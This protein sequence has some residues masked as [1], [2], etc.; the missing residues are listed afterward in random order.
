MLSDARTLPDGTVLEA[1]LLI[2][3]AGV[4]GI[5]IAREFSE[6]SGTTTGKVILLEAGGDEYDPATQA[7]YEG[8]VIGNPSADTDITRLRYFGG[9]SNHWH[10]FCRPLDPIDFEQRS[11]V[12]HSGWPFDLSSLQPYYDRAEPI[13]ELPGTA[14]DPASWAES[15]APIFR[16]SMMKGRLRPA[17]FQKS[18]PTLMGLAY[19]DGLKASS[20]IDIYFWANAMELVANDSGQLIEQV[21]CACLEGPRF[22]VR[23]KQVVLATGGIENARLLLAS[24]R[25]QPAG[26][27]NGYDRVGRYFMDHPAHYAGQIVLSSPS[28]LARAPASK[29]INTQCTLA[30]DV[31]RDESLVRFLTTLYPQFDDGGPPKGYIALRQISRAL[32]RGRLPREAGERFGM[33]FAD[34]NGA[35]R[36][37]YD[38]M[39]GGARMLGLHIH[40]EVA[41]NPD[42]RVL[43]G[44]ETD[45]LGMPKIVLDWRLTDLDRRSLRRGLEIVGEEMGK[46][47]LGRLKLAD[48]ILEEDD[49][50]PGNGSYHH[51]GTTRMH[52]DPKKGVVDADCRVHGIDNLSIAGS[53]VFP[54]CGFA[55]PTLTLTAL[56]LRL[57]DRLKTLPN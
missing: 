24:R 21:N 47:G 55:N 22:S 9:S 5:T 52:P 34:L 41:P 4:A 46:T 12:P 30:P 56:A 25:Q 50:I 14:Y 23:A 49:A 45:A 43:L 27:G 19:G 17:V 48:W 1:D 26:I 2:I 29:V 11:W 57:A 54:T 37:I 10:G 18:P 40:P 53:S 7:L 15:M 33:L 8:E 13:L 32:G 51:I 39:F 36:G 6:V 28:D 20:R 42:S 38:R 16:H 44:E 31:E 3:G 35:A